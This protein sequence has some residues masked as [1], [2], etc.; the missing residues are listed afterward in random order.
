[1]FGAGKRLEE[2]ELMNWFIHEAPTASCLETMVFLS[3]KRTP[4]FG[5]GLDFFFN[6]WVSSDSPML[7]ADA[8]DLRIL[9]K[10]RQ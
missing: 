6:Q 2:E 7:M 8:N 1:M 10:E 9:P 5:N 3:C 4:I